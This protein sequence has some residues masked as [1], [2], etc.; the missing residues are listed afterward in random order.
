MFPLEPTG[1]VASESDSDN[2]MSHATDSEKESFEVRIWKI[3]KTE[4]LKELL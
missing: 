3:R 2:S 1:G 4:L